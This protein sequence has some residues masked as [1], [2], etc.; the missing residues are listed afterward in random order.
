MH[1][2]V[3]QAVQPHLFPAPRPGHFTTTPSLV[4]LLEGKHLLVRF[5]LAATAG[6]AL[7]SLLQLR[8][9]RRDG[10]MVTHIIDPNVGQSAPRQIILNPLG[11]RPGG[12]L[13]TTKLIE[14]RGDPSKTVNF[15][16]PGALLIGAT[17][18][19]VQL[20]ERSPRE[21]VTGRLQFVFHD[22]VRIGLWFAPMQ[23]FTGDPSSMLPYLRNAL[24]VSEVRVLGVLPA[25]N[26]ILHHSDFD[27][28]RNNPACD[29]KHEL[30][31]VYGDDDAPPAF[32]T[33]DPHYTIVLGVWGQSGGCAFNSDP[34]DEDDRNSLVAVTS[35][36]GAVAAHEVGHVLS[37]EHAGS[38][39]GECTGGDCEIGW[40]YPHGT[41][42]SDGVV[43]DFGAQITPI[44]PPP[45]DR[46]P[47]G[48]WNVHMV[49]PCEGAFVDIRRSPCS[50]A[51]TSG[52]TGGQDDRGNIPH[53]VMS[54]FNEPP[55]SD[56][57][58]PTGLH[59]W[60]SS[61]TYT[62][63]Y[64]AI[65]Y[66]TRP[67]WRD[68]QDSCGSPGRSDASPSPDRSSSS[69]MNSLLVR[70][71]ID[72]TG[73]LT[74]Q[75]VWKRKSRRRSI[76]RA[77]KEGITITM[78]SRNQETLYEKTVALDRDDDDEGNRQTFATRMPM[79]DDFYSMAFSKGEQVLSEVY[80]SRNPP[81]VVAQLASRKACAKGDELTIEW[82]S[83]DRDGDTL[84]TIVEVLIDGR[85]YPVGLVDRGSEHTALSMSK[86]VF[87]A[88]SPKQKKGSFVATS[89]KAIRV[90]V[91]D[92]FHNTSSE[93]EVEDC[94]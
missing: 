32:D 66:G 30:R 88:A 27:P 46:S 11:L 57:L 26:L 2:E 33:D 52:V 21:P 89:K 29:L 6:R 48:A 12:R 67:T 42:R 84:A 82:K 17:R 23:N 22:P 70:G 35:T 75:P 58:F 28:A 39:H 49:D 1:V 18:A 10:S 34:S 45:A 4:P 61:L 63:M 44:S 38:E 74:L 20:W 9:W 31:A 36:D 93:I 19:E 81:Q 40:P 16:V 83:T 7:S 25:L 65:R 68:C 80:V 69:G 50:I 14:M 3:T 24:P 76:V 71:F 62:R 86:K 64:N 73:S 13:S 15:V 92:G 94:L 79:I 78:K 85:T 43:A 41:M 5:Y 59:Q 72:E 47:Y 77:A 51:E 53:D 37:M 90:T 8:L 54:Y 60:V 56:F 91:S 87:G 55:P